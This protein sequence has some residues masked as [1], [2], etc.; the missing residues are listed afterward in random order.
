MRDRA[1][2]PLERS[3]AKHKPLEVLTRL[4]GETILHFFISTI[5]YEFFCD[6]FQPSHQL[7]HIVSKARKH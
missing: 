7:D 6:E 4:P 2:F 1:V 5:K 3:T